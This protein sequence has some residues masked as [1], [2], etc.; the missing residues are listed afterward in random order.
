MEN[1]LVSESEDLSTIEE[2]RVKDGKI[3]AR[4]VNAGISD[5]RSA[6]EAEWTEVSAEQLSNHVL[7]NTDVARWLERN[8]GWRHLL[9]ACVGQQANQDETNQ[10]DRD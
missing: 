3:E 10:M 2:Y 5:E 6:H 4:I 7:S 1:T 8:L 9:R